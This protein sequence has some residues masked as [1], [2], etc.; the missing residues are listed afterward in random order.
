MARG[1]RQPISSSTG[2]AKGG[3]SRRP[4]SAIGAAA[5][6]AQGI[7]SLRHRRT[8][9]AGKTA[10]HQQEGPGL[11]R[12]LLPGKPLRTTTLRSYGFWTN[13]LAG[14]VVASFEERRL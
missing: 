9:G 1:T 10:T 8:A 13:G 6:S 4:G 14:N 5:P 2:G 11:R 7:H 3:Q 12:T